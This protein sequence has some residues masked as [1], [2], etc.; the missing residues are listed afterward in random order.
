MAD[1]VTNIIIE[2]VPTLIGIFI[3]TLAA[4]ATDRRA[5]QRRK[6][7]R[8]QIVLRALLQEI[9]DN[10]KTLQ[11]VKPAFSNTIWGRSFYLSTLAWETA[12]AGGDLPEVIGFELADAIAGQ[13]ALFVRIRYYVDLLTRLWFAPQTIQ[14]YDDIRR[15]FHKAIIDAM[16]QAFSRHAKIVERIKEHPSAAAL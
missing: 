15:G 9:G 16:N 7:Q 8:A 2:T 4:L 1:I 10:N 11:E 5:A 6:R 14:G 13:Y 12:M 3:G